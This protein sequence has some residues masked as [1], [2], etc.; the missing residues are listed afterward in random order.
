MAQNYPVPNFNH[1]A[2]RQTRWMYF[3]AFSHDSLLLNKNHIIEKELPDYESEDE[4]Y[5]R[6]RTVI[7]DKARHHKSEMVN[8]TKVS[9]NF[10]ILLLTAIANLQLDS[11]Y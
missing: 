3:L 5:M 7:M 4:A 8:N 6:L 11:C 1:R 9:D 10:S 2:D